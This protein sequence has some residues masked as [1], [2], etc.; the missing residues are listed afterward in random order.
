MDTVEKIRNLER[1][2]RRLDPSREQRQALLATAGDYAQNL[3]EALPDTK[4]Y[5]RDPG[6]NGFLDYPLKDAPTDIGEL[7]QFFRREVDTTGILPASGGQMGYIPGGGLFPSALG[8]FL[9]DISNRYSGVSFAGPGAARMEGSLVRW[10][11]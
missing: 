1:V 9:A 2:A 10:M 6:R 8:D 3:L 5:I 4:T 7:L 11:C